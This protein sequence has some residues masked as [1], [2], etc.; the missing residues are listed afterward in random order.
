MNEILDELNGYDRAECEEDER[1]Y[2]ERM[3]RLR[4]V[5][6]RPARAAFSANAEA[7]DDLRWATDGN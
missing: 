1:R 3:R 2:A 4:R 5:R 7:A 6:L